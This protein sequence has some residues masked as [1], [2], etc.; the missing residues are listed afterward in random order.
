M[1]IKFYILALLSLSFMTQPILAKKK[2]FSVRSEY[3]KGRKLYLG[4]KYLNAS[5]VL[6]N[7]LKKYPSH[8]P[9]AILLARIYYRVKN[10]KSAGQLFEKM[11]IQNL[12]P[13]E[14]YEYGHVFSHLNNYDRCY[15]AFSSINKEHPV[16]D[17]AQFYAA[18]CSIR[19]KNYVNAEYSLR[20]SVVLPSRLAK[21]RKLYLKHV[22]SILLNKE[23]ALL[24]KVEKRA[25][26]QMRANLKKDLKDE[27][28][29][30]PMVTVTNSKSSNNVKE[31]PHAPIHFGFHFIHQTS[32]Y[33]NA[34]DISETPSIFR[35][36]YLDGPSFKLPS[37][38]KNTVE[39]GLHGGIGIDYSTSVGLIRDHGFENKYTQYH[40]LFNLYKDNAATLSL[41]VLPFIKATLLK[42]YKLY[43]GFEYERV[44]PEVV[45]T[46]LSGTHQLISKL[47]TEDKHWLLS[48][49][50]NSRWLRNDDNQTFIWFN[51]FHI[52]GGWKFSESFRVLAG[53]KA[54]FFD[55]F[56]NQIDGPERVFIVNIA[57]EQDFPFNTMLN[58]SLFAGVM[59]ENLTYDIAPTEVKS[60]GTKYGI[61]I[62]GSLSPAPWLKV[63][64]NHRRSLIE[65]TTTDLN[66]PAVLEK[67]LE[68][69][70]NNIIQTEMKIILNLIF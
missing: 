21:R 45:F 43:L 64:A 52:H 62:S 24:K 49:D 16:H 6:A 38:K 67:F 10:Y 12:E 30:P 35:F 65:W 55:Y 58:A 63:E 23:K 26:R 32:K 31:P 34:A 33:E 28:I 39:A 11:T 68:S 53:L 59:Q 4:K 14:K 17:L 22:R 7:I 18:I 40:S 8:E 19:L 66:N 61:Q 42:K 54:D 46:N 27:K 13:I 3:K 57:A 70:S 25:L 15:A 44:F 9:S 56:E 47:E 50:F 5:Y 36:R 48:L 41:R 51:H 2:K 29:L 1:Q 37:S 69:T 60:E 20:H